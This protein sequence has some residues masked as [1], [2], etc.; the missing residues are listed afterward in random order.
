ME[1]MKQESCGTGGRVGGIG[2]GCGGKDYGPVRADELPQG[3]DL[4]RLNDAG[5]CCPQCR[6]DLFEDDAACPSCGAMVGASSVRAESS[7]SLHVLL[8]LAGALVA[9]LLIASAV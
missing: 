4:R 7:R 1:G 3:D 2:C 5:R 9:G 6:T 8:G